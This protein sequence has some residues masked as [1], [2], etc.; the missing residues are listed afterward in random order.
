MYNAHQN[1]SHPAIVE[2]REA[3]GQGRKVR[4][5]FACSCAKPQLNNWQRDV[6]PDIFFM[7]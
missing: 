7:S 1:R 6:I 5:A 2:L 3:L 4:K